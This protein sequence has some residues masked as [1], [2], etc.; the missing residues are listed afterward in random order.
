VSDNLQEVWVR[1]DVVIVGY[2]LNANIKPAQALQTV[3]G[4]DL[5]TAKA[6]TRQFP[7]PVLTGL[8]LSRAESVS[9]QLTDCGAKV[10]VR[11]SRLSHVSEPDKQTP[12]VRPFPVDEESGN[13]AIGEILAPMGR[14]SAAR[15]GSTP[16]PS[17]RPSREELD[18]ALRESLRP[19]AAPPAVRVSLSPE[20][21]AAFAG[22][23]NFESIDG[24]T[25]SAAKLE[26]DEVAFRSIQREP[27]A[28]NVRAKR[29]PSLWE[30][31]LRWAQNLGSGALDWTLSLLW[32]GLIA[33]LTL[34]AVGYALNPED[35]V[36]ALKLELL[37]EPT[38]QALGR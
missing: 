33:A 23:T 28:Q 13:Y 24:Y 22:I 4:L 9:Q 18:E 34:V 19:Q 17:R 38:R 21:D 3:L 1:Y 7:A 32:L 12:S 25:D 5:E 26:V 20:H 36:G 14:H 35:I 10:E 30:R 37:T 2:K 27:V 29:G 8:S 15:A 11:E 16:E 6:M 31:L